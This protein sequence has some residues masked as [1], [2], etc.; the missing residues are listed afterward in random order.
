MTSKPQPG[1]HW[2][3][4]IKTD[5]A[6]PLQEVEVLQFGPK[7]AG[8]RVHIRYLDGEY[9]GLD[10]WVPLRR[11]VVLWDEAAALMA[12]ERRMRAI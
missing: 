11:L 10:E 3:Y 7:V 6:E 8:Q 9:P 5:L 4:R 12:D 1:E 2:G